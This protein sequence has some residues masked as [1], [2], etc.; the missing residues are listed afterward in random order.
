MYQITISVSRLNKLAK[1]NRGPAEFADLTSLSFNIMEMLTCKLCS[2]TTAR[3]F[4]C[5]LPHLKWMNNCIICLY[6]RRDRRCFHGSVSC[7]SVSFCF[8][9]K[10]LIMVYLTICL[11]HPR[12]QLV[13][14][15]INFPFPRQ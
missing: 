12:I 9:P 2:G 1:N 10:K 14:I 13:N 8:L 6:I 7:A 4:K 3:F 15:V 11:K 5:L